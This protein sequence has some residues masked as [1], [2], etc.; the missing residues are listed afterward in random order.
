M[1]KV[2]C[3]LNKWMPG[4][5]ENGLSIN[6]DGRLLK[7]GVRFDGPSGREESKTL[8]F[9]GVSFHSVAAFPGAPSLAGKYEFEFSTGTVIEAQNSELSDLWAAHWRR[10]GLQR[11]CSHFVMFWGSE[12]K[13]V[14]VIAESFELS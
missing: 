2:V 13:A 8:L 5:G 12:N 1:G 11:S 10:S 4:H 9:E 14:H 6:F 3:D 7:I